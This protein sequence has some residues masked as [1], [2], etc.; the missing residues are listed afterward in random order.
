MLIVGI[1]VFMIGFIVGSIC[2][3]CMCIAKDINDDY[4]D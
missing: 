2:M 3:A 1:G 4:R